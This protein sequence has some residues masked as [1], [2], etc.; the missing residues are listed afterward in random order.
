MRVQDAIDFADILVDMTKRYCAFLPRADIVGGSTD[1]ATTAKH[2]SF[3]WIR[4]KHL[5]PIHSQQEDNR[6]CQMKKRTARPSFAII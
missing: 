1:I 5:C 6:P 3:K 4:R 2:K